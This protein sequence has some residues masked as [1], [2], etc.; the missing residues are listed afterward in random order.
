M[1]PSRRLVDPWVGGFSSGLWDP[2]LWGGDAVTGSFPVSRKAETNTNRVAHWLLRHLRVLLYGL[3]WNCGAN[4]SAS[5]SRGAVWD[6]WFIYLLFLLLLSLRV[7]HML[8]SFLKQDLSL[9]LKWGQEFYFVR[10]RHLWDSSHDSPGGHFEKPSKLGLGSAFT[11]DTMSLTHVF[12]AKK[13][14]LNNCFPWGMWPRGLTVGQAGNG[15]MAC[16]PVSW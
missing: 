16:H 5:D 12:E 3:K 6:G 1:G 2:P 15:L 7:K 10:W 11:K 8:P 4:I 14:F 13:A 9:C